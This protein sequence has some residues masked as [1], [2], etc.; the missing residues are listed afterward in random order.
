MSYGARMQQVSSEQVRHQVERFLRTGHDAPMSRRRERS[1]DVCFE[2]F[3]TTDNPAESM[4]LSCLHLGYYLASWGMLRGSSF[5]FRE[6]NLLHYVPV[7]EVIERHHGVMRGVDTDDYRDPATVA[8]LWEVWRELRQALL[9]DGGRATTLVS[10]VMM[11][12][13]GCLP[14]FDTFFMRTFRSLAVTPAERRAFAGVTDDA[15]TILADFQGT[16][17]TV[18]DELRAE[19]PLIGFPGGAETGLRMTRAKVV[20]IFG[21]GYSYS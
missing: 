18:I 1:W 9:P 19:Y 3:H 15:L 6:T 17:A 2:H 13:W 21:F 7:I 8:H 10:K 14:S 11:G 4:E 5:L 12:V 16:H 20:D